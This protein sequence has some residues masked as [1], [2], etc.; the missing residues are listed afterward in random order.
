MTGLRNRNR[1]KI[2]TPIDPP[3]EG[4]SMFEQLLADVIL[5]SDD[6]IKRMCDDAVSKQKQ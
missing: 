6:R 3:T 4:I 1:N 5:E 2:G